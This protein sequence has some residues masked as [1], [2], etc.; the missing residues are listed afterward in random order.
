MN[1]TFSTRIIRVHIRYTLSRIKSHL[2]YALKWKS[3]SQYCVTLALLN[4]FNVEPHTITSNENGK[5]EQDSKW[6]QKRKKK[7]FNYEDRRQGIFQWKFLFALKSD[8]NSEWIHTQFWV[9]KKWFYVRFQLFFRFFFKFIHILYHS[10]ITSVE[11]KMTVSVSSLKYAHFSWKFRV[12]VLYILVWD[13][14]N[15]IRMKFNGKIRR[16]C[17]V[18]IRYPINIPAQKKRNFCKNLVCIFY[19]MNKSYW[20]DASESMFHAISI[21]R[22]SLIQK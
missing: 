12:Y 5:T 2:E 1:K 4:V 15:G 13:E 20:W 11:M 14:S 17:A 3:I 19:E 6:D 7:H 18:I 22:L 21:F 16:R 8:R 10:N 9:I